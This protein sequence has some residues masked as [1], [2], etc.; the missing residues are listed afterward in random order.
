M[1]SLWSNKYSAMVLYAVYGIGQFP[2][3]TAYA[4]I[5]LASICGFFV[6]LKRVI[7]ACLHVRPRHLTRNVV[8]VFVFLALYLCQFGL[9]TNGVNDTT[10]T[11]KNVGSFA[12]QLSKVAAAWE[13]Q[14]EASASQEAKID[15]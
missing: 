2:G 6:V 4:L 10:L 7:Y 3:S 5:N 8:I 1:E 15:C 12:I 9:C 14:R 13:L 11:S